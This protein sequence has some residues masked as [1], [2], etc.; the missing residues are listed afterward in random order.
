MIA[1]SF[2]DRLNT[3]SAKAEAALSV[4]QQIAAD[5]EEAA[6]SKFDIAYDIQSEIE[7]LDAQI[8]E[9][10]YLRE[11]AKDHANEHSVQADKIRA[12]VGA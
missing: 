11:H 10:V 7:H 6:Q 1:P 4:F 8:R 3:E 5:L 2:H 9:L 12:L